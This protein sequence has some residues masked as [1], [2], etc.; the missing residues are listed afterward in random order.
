[1]FTLSAAQLIVKAEDPKVSNV[2]FAKA[3]LE[4]IPN[5]DGSY[6]ALLDA[7]IAK[8]QLAL[9][10]IGITLAQVKRTRATLLALQQRQR[11]NFAS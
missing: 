10:A 9:E 3:Y 4:Y 11:K 8:R 5:S 7:L 6:V 1:M 2:D